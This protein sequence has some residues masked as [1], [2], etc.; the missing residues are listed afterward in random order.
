MSRSGYN[1]DKS[2]YVVKQVTA[3]GAH[4]DLLTADVTDAGQVDAAFRHTKVPIAGII[5]GAMVLRVGGTSQTQ[6]LSLCLPLSDNMTHR[7]DRST[8]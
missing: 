3:L 6:T 1:D 2:R 8:R 4:I 7:T 5:Q